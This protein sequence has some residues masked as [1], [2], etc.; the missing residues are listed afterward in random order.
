MWQ[1]YV[2][3]DRNCQILVEN[4]ENG[5]KSFQK[6][7]F[8]QILGKMLQKGDKN[9]QILTKSLVNILKII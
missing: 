1:K 2:K 3:S 7:E 5:L 9:H 6:I 4:L 8:G